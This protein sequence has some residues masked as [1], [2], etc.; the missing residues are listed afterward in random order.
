MND[1]GDEDRVPAG[2][3]AGGAGGYTGVYADDS[4]QRRKPSQAQKR[5]GRPLDELVASKE[6]IQAVYLYWVGEIDSLAA[7]QRA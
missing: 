1:A 3:C 4:R 5:C 7:G 2:N 6:R